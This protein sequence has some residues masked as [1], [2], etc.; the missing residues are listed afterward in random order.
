M[1]KTVLFTLLFLLTGLAVTLYLRYPESLKPK[2]ASE[3][4]TGQRIPV[5]VLEPVP[6][7]RPAIL[8][9]EVP[10]SADGTR[11][12]LPPLDS[13][14]EETGA[15]ASVLFPEDGGDG[16]LT[17]DH[18]IQ[19]FVLLVHSLAE[20]KLPLD[21]MPVK[22]VGGPFQV[23]TDNGRAFIDPQ[24][25]NRYAPYIRL[26][27]RIPM[28]TAGRAYAR[29]YPLFQQ[30]Y[31]ELGVVGGQFHQ[32]LLEGID[33]LL[34]T[35]EPRQPVPLIQPH[36]LYR[37]ADPDLENLSAGQKTL[38]RMGPENAAVVKNKLREFRKVLTR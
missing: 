25:Y 3:A 13:A 24:N 30:A 27:E 16:I 19:R 37:F 29:L 23:M 31:D 28:E 14:D 4:P 35:P 12:P 26:L 20:H 10:T 18:L 34:S 6:E 38:L 2:A 9:R 5:E 11:Q 32:R 8:Q 17:R 1:K 22:P 7:R 36:V 15:W 33:H 21:K